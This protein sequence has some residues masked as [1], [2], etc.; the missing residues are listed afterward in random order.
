M[1]EIKQNLVEG[2]AVQIHKFGTYRTA[3]TKEKTINSPISKGPKVIPAH[4]RVK[5]S[6]SQKLKQLVK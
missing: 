2:I 6:P 4:N 5:F 1:N 3:P